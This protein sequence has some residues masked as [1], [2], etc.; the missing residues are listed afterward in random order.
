MRP[1]LNSQFFKDIA[2]DALTNDEREAYTIGFLDALNLRVNYVLVSKM[3]EEQLAKYNSLVEL[4]DDVE[5]ENYQKSQFPDLDSITQQEFD[6]LKQ[7]IMS[8]EEGMGE[9]EEDISGDSPLSQ[10]PVPPR[11][12]EKVEQTK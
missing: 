5:I 12:E 4:G 6:K 1:K 10:P 7:E 3:N 8:G 2:Q 11:F 9:E